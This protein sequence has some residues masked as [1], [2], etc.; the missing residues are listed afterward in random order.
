MLPGEP[1]A[2]G[3][4]A[5]EAVTGKRHAAGR[6]TARENIAGLVDPGSFTEYGA[7]AIAAQRRR[8]SLDDLIAN[9]PADGLMNTGRRRRLCYDRPR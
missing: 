9:T 7:L 5:R 8:R 1:G 3:A 4:E 6:W 2:E